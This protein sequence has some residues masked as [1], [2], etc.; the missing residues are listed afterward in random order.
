MNTETRWMPYATALLL[1]TMITGILQ[2]AAFAAN[3]RG[4]SKADTTEV[5]G[6]AT[7]PNRPVTA[8]SVD[9]ANKAVALAIPQAQPPSTSTRTTVLPSSSAPPQQTKRSSK[10]WIIIAVAAGGAAA[11]AFAVKGGGG[12]VP[13][14]T[15]TITVGTPSIG[16]PQ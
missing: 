7:L 1:V 4:A 11:A 14:A 13:P 10:K 6:V 2:P 9:P 3:D 5:K 12:G 15:P 8:E 16:G